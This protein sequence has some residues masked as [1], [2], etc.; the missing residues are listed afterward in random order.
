MAVV[1][2]SRIQVRRG[3]KNSGIGVPQL[4]SAEFAWAVDTQEL[5][6]GNGSL[7][8]G[9][10]YVGNT[11]ILTE[12]DN[13]IEL[14]SA[15]EFAKPDLSIVG[16]VPRSLQGKLDEIEV[17]VLDFGATP[18]G[19]TDCTD[20]FETACNQLF[21]STD[22]RYR[23]KLK[24]PNG[25]YLFTRN[26]RI[27]ANTIIEG[28]N[29][30]KTVLDINNFSIVFI[31]ETGTE[32]GSF[33]SGD[34]PENVEIRNVTVSHNTGQTDLTGCVNFK[35]TDVKWVGNY[36]LGDVVFVAEN[37]NAVYN[38]P[39]VSAGGNIVVSGS[40]V[41]TTI[42][43]SFAVTYVATLGQ[44][45]GLLNSDPTFVTLFSASVAGTSLKIT[46]NSSSAASSLIT[47]NINVVSQAD[48][49]S[50]PAS[51]SPILQEYSDGSDDARSSVFWSNDLFGTRTT[52][53][54]FHGCDFENTPIAIECQQ[55]TAFDT[56]VTF[57]D[58]KFF[59]CDTGVYVGGVQGQ[60]HFWNIRDTVFEQIANQAINS[61]IGKGMKVLRCKFKNCGNGT[62]SSSNPVAPIV[63][64]GNYFDN[65]LVDCTSN[66]HQESSIVS[67]TTIEGIIEVDNAAHSSFLDR[68]YSEIYLSDSPRPLSIFSSANQVIRLEYTLSLNTHVRVGTLT[69]TVN[70]DATSVTISDN[71][72]YSSGGTTMTDF[73]FSADLLDNDSDSVVD[74]VLLKYVNPVGNAAAGF[75]SYSLGYAL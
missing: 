15:Y 29:Q 23:K 20:A 58:C 67:L 45:V 66:R 2:I 54:K 50:A 7:T 63:S 40:G 27:P 55:S 28:E 19:S 6:I 5:F 71:Y 73:Q 48:G 14:A 47:A 75:I 39:I 3:Q 25:T 61:I 42:T 69:M 59:I 4:S 32:Q 8:E 34:R 60:E 65:V 38:I 41:S 31:S 62:G 11:K 37:A 74:T 68:N 49:L 56:E 43:Q 21:R 57:D 53:I 72:T 1:Q 70:T 17:S 26:L 24:V 52:D 9:A 46:A 22:H 16:T 18:D 13:L 44:L 12:H 51:V 35:F 36:E 10:P 33:T 30:D 64:F